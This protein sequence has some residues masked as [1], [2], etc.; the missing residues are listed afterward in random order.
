MEQLLEPRLLFIYI[1]FVAYL[2]LRLA[3][4]GEQDC[5]AAHNV[6]VMFIVCDPTS[7]I[8]IVCSLQLSAV[9]GSAACCAGTTQLLDSKLPRGSVKGGLSVSLWS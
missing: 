2:R 5:A 4:K 9:Q 7:M 8:S 1:S 6:Q 3:N